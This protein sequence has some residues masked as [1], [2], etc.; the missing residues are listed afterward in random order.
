MAVKGQKE[1]AYHLCGL[2]NCHLNFFRLTSL[3]LHT[4]LCLT[5]TRGTTRVSHSTNTEKESTPRY[6]SKIDTLIAKYSQVP[7][8][9]SLSFTFSV[10]AYSRK[11]PQES[12]KIFVE[13]VVLVLGYSLEPRPYSRVLGTVFSVM[14]IG[15]S[16]NGC[17]H[18]ENQFDERKQDWPVHKFGLR[19]L[20][21]LDAFQT[22]SFSAAHSRRRKKAP[23][24]RSPPGDPPGEIFRKRRGYCAC[25]RPSSNVD[26]F[27]LGRLK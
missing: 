8:Y 11:T 16:Y 14:T 21:R 3:I 27:M 4:L 7:C 1:V 15:L 26:L 23:H 2:G 13:H 6:S 5:Y 19:R 18:L 25:L 12:S 24:S 17:S 20:K 9:Q 22:V 10:L